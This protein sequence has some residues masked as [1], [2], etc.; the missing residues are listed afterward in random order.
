MADVTEKALAESFDHNDVNQTGP[1]AHTLYRELRKQCPIGHSAAHGGFTYLLN[2]KDV[3]DVA[4]QPTPFGSYPNS[5]PHVPVPRP[6]VPLQIN[7]PAH[8][9]YRTMLNPFFTAQ[10]GAT[11]AAAVRR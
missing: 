1:E 6:M 4:H 2:Y 11:L 8:Q 5:V 9:G 10:R 7:P 3:N